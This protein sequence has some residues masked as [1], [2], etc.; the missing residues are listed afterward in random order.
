M[1]CAVAA[2]LSACGNAPKQ[3]GTLP[4]SSSWWSSWSSPSTASNAEQSPGFYYKVGRPYQIAGT[5]YYPKEDWS[6]NETGIASWY[7]E[8]FHGRYTADGEVFDLNS[9]TAAHRTLPL[10]CVVRV[11]NLENG[12]SI[13]LRVNDRGPYARGRIIDV[14]RRAAQ[15]LGFEGSGTAKVRVQ[16]MVPDS[17]DVA[18]AARRGG[19]RFAAAAPPTPAAVV[20]EVAS[21]PLT[22]P[23]SV[24]EAMRGGSGPAVTP[25]PPQVEFAQNKPI[26]AP[27][28]R[29]VA[30]RVAAAAP[31][32]TTHPA[33]R[34]A[35]IRV[36]DNSRAAD[37]RPYIFDDLPAPTNVEMPA[38]EPPS[39]P[40]VLPPMPEQVSMVSVKPTQI[41]IQAGAFSE[42][43][44]ARRMQSKLRGL[45]AP[46]KVTSVAVNGSAVYRVRVGP[47]P[48]VDAADDMLNRV[49]VNGVA[50]AR[51]VV[52]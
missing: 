14:S 35:E 49:V 31:P 50:E 27:A 21:A 25:T 43:G 47:I 20:A 36:A 17:M 4:S 41:Y 33:S 45:G 48:S 52:D 8:Q 3:G 39:Q 19:T 38:S 15:L 10:P 22:L 16:I 37:N 9:L 51:I 30:V 23:V 12:R 34:P 44:N 11:T 29:P 40:L 1:W 5:W 26:A 46:V 7:G 2:T 28:P 18:A 24:L 42:S 6:Y 32:R 13:K